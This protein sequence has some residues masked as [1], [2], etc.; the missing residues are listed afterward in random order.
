MNDEF[1]AAIF[2]KGEK[3]CCLNIQRKLSFNDYSGI[4]SMY[5]YIEW[6]EEK[7]VYI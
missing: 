3:P 4:L 2:P 5:R 1:S 7:C 6:Q